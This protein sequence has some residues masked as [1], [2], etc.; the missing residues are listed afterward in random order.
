[1][2]L[3]ASQEGSPLQEPDLRLQSPRTVRNKVCSPS[4]QVCDILLCHPK[5]IKETMNSNSQ[6][7]PTIA[8]SLKQVAAPKMTTCR[9]PLALPT[10]HRPVAFDGPVLQVHT[11][12]LRKVPE[13]P[14][15]EI[16]SKWGSER[17]MGWDGK[18]GE[19]SFLLPCD[20]CHFYE[21]LASCLPHYCPAPHPQP[22]L[23]PKGASF[24]NVCLQ[25]TPLP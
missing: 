15:K 9:T 11:A 5:L 17:R 6:R 8:A 2:S 12:G 16:V 20:C 21:P 1:M 25:F 13:G 10:S 22:N 3:S 23:V 14:L 7:F 19:R 24:G 18:W 4:H